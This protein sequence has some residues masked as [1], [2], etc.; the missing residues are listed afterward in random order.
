M[1]MDNDIEKIVEIGKVLL[2][3]PT[4][5]SIYKDKFD[6]NTIDFEFVEKTNS[7]QFTTNH[8]HHIFKVTLYTDISLNFDDRIKSGEIEGYDTIENELWEYGIDP[9]YLA[10]IIIPEKILNIILPKGK[11]EPKVAIELLIIGDEG[12][13]IWND[14]MFG[15]PGF[16]N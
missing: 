8:E 1:V 15:R 11:G 6:I 2:N 4:L 10:D 7:S 12:Q 3:T 14:H 16:T 5:R 13:V 9:F